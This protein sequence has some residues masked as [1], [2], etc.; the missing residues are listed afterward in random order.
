MAVHGFS[1]SLRLTLAIL[2]ASLLLSGCSDGD[3]KEE[4]IVRPAKLHVVAKAEDRLELD[5]P[6]VIQ[7]SSSSTL[8]FQVGGLLTS[9]PVREGQFVRQGTPV[10][11]LDQRRY[12]NAV[13]SARAEYA[14]AQSEYLSSVRLLEEDAIARIAVNQRRAK[15]DIAQANLDS[16]R[17]DLSDTILRAPFSG[18]VATKHV[19]NFEN[20]QPGQ[21]IVTLQ[22]TGEVEALVNIPSTVVANINR[23]RD[24]QA[25]I[26]LN[27]APDV[28]IPGV[29]RSVSTQG[30]TATQ[31]FRVKFAF[32]PP[33]GIN[34]LPGM[35]GSVVGSR[36]LIT[37][38]DSPA[39][40]TVPLGSVQA[41]GKKRFV[42]V[43]NKKT[44]KVKKREVQVGEDVGEEVAIISG[45]KAG[46]TIVAAGAA[47]LYDDMK[48]R[49]YK[50]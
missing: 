11:R 42:W 22:S 34:V 50:G 20:V 26:I 12:S 8:T 28:R 49:P 47:Y 35:T 9:F 16:T 3:L 10:A 33:P 23:T 32:T 38:E 15:R 44:M 5:F 37:D 17:K 46:E 30:D 39:S 6:A 2:S 41:E 48:I 13:Q 1:G 18:V 29:F 14:N 45:L 4:E 25:F 21:E 24:A 19:S 31:T 27:S 40:I 43:V 7:A 36:E